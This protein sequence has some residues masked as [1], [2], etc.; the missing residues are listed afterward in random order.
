MTTI[1]NLKVEKKNN[2]IGSFHSKRS[3]WNSKRKYGYRYITTV[4]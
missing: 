2:Q 4:F 3:S 1:D